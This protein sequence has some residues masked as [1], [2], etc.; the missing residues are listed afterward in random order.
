MSDNAA[1]APTPAGEKAASNSAS[2]PPPIGTGERM[3][4]GILIGFSAAGIG[5]AI[6]AK[7]MEQNEIIIG[8]TTETI[9]Q[10]SAVL[11]PVYSQH[12]GV[13]AALLGIVGYTLIFLTSIAAIFL[14]KQ[15]RDTDDGPVPTGAREWFVRVRRW[16][17]LGAFGMSVYFMLVQGLWIGNFCPICFSSAV[18]SLAL[19]LVEMSR[20]RPGRIGWLWLG[21]RQMVVTAAIVA[22]LVGGGMTTAFATQAWDPI[23]KPKAA[24]QRLFDKAAKAELPL[25]GTGR[26][27]PQ[28][29]LASREGCPLCLQ[30]FGGTM[31]DPR[32]WALLDRFELKLAEHPEGGDVLA[33]IGVQA[34]PELH[35]I[36]PS[37]RAIE[38]IQ[39]TLSTEEVLEF[40]QRNAPEGQLRG[41]SVTE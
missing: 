41:S 31:D 30:F 24:M 14:K 8:C 35:V 9:D 10:C 32:I 11:L 3:R 6:G 20:R 17:I 7:L 4:D 13:S 12:L 36:S 23:G 2:G 38:R 33:A 18:A 21:Q 37:G 25:Y 29:V 22:V 40:L 26:G 27:R 16:L 1:A 28:L 34:T 15:Y 5:L 19:L 39:R